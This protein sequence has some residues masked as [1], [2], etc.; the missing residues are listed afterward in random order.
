M[1][2]LLSNHDSVVMHSLHYISQHLLLPLPVL[3]CVAG[4]LLSS[5]LSHLPSLGLLSA[6]SV[7]RPIISAPHTLGIH[8]MSEIETVGLDRR[9]NWPAED[10][11]STPA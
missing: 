2:S 7:R 9:T 3:T 5:S 4:R 10:E 1:M 8:V 6:C 11:T